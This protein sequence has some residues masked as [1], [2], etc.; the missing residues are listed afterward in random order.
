MKVLIACEE[1]QRVC[2]AFRNKGHEAYSCDIQEPSGHHPGW[3]ILD[4]C[5][6]ILGGGKFMTMDMR[7]H[8]VD[9]WDLI[10]AHPP[11]TYLTNVASRM[12][13]IN[14]V[15]SVTRNQRIEMINART[16]ERIKAVEFFMEIVNAD[17]EKICVE[18]PCGVVNTFYRK[19]D[20]IIHPYFFAEN[21]EDKENY[22]MKK[23]CL[24]LKN[25]PE[26][27]RTSNLPAPS[28][29][30]KYGWEESCKK[31]DQDKNRSKQ[32][33]KTFTAV[34]KAMAEQWGGC[35]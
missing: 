3:H 21:E 13:S 16:R 31:L 24:W 25:L 8:S 22:V 4:N 17:C 7:E 20:Q 15:R 34:A 27:R 33:S 6:K 9:K 5:L 11:C 26:L 1:S 14:G 2:S 10:I 19:P 18:N 30:G 23:T 29:T 28:K 32:R 12:H 35:E